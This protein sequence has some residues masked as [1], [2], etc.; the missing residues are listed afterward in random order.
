M[1]KA[2]ATLWAATLQLVINALNDEC[3]LI[4]MCALSTYL[5]E[6]LPP[7]NT[8]DDVEVSKDV[9]KLVKA[10]APVTTL[11]PDELAYVLDECNLILEGA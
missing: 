11:T 3:N 1:L 6:Q 8:Y 9:V 4:I 5:T 10:V 7:P 2:Y